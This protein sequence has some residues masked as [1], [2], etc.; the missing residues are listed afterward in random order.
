MWAIRVARRFLPA[1]KPRRHAQPLWP[2]GI[3]MAERANQCAFFLLLALAARPAQAIDYSF[4]GPT[5]PAGC[6]G[7]N[8]SY[9]CGALAFAAGDTLSVAQATAVTVNGALSVGADALINAGGSG[10]DLSFDISGAVT[11]GAGATVN[12]HVASSA[13]VTIG[14][15]VNLDGN[16]ST[17]TGAVSVGA[18]AVVSGNISTVDG[19]VTLGVGTGVSGSISTS[20]TGAISAGASSTVGGNISSATG[21]IDIGAGSVVGG[22]ISSSVNGAIGLGATVTVTGGIT[23]ATGA[24][25]VGESS[26]VNGPIASTV[27]GA[28]SL[29]ASSQAGSTVTSTSGAITIGAGGS[30]AALLSTKG[31][32]LITIGDGALINSVFCFVPNDQSCVVNNSN[33][34]MP[35]ASPP[36]SGAAAGAFECLETGSNATWSSAARKPLYTKLAGSNFSFDIAALSTNGSLV[37]NYAPAGGSARYVKVELF[38]DS[39]PPASCST[40]ANIVATQIVTFSPGA[41]SGAAGRTLSG[42][43]NLTSAHKVLRCRVTECAS[44]TCGSVTALAPS[45]SSDQFS[46]RPQALTLQTSALAPAPSAAATP[47]IKA[48]ASFNLSASA[49]ASATSTASVLTLDAGKL[50]AQVPGQASSVQSGGVVGALT[51]S[52]LTVNAS[53]VSAVYT[54]VGYLYLAPGAFRDDT[55]T[56][57]DRAAG[58]CID[59]TTGNHDLSDTLMGGKYGC[60][61]GNLAPVSF[62]R[63]IPDH[64]D[65]A[66]EAGVPMPCP[67]ALSCAPAGYVYA[68]QP[69]GV[70]VT[71]RNLA[72]ATTLNYSG[73]FSHAVT[74]QAWDAPGSTVLPN[75]PASPA[76]SVLGVSAVPAASFVAGLASVNGAASPAYRFPFAWPAAGSTL[77][78]PSAI[79]VRAIETPAGSADGVTSQR[80]SASVEGGV[81]VVAGRL[82]LGNNYGSEVLPLPINLTAQYWDGAQFVT[83]TGDHASVFNAADMVFSNCRGAL[84]AGAGVCIGGLSA[85]PASLVLVAGAARFTLNA[86]GPGNTG[87]LDV[88]IGTYPWLPSSK[89]R[90]TF[91]VYKGGPVIYSRELY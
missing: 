31:P 78:P 69:F 19:G 18:G 32:G 79:Y 68:A 34:P 65:S 59:D 39:T 7:G 67:A 55:F 17:T 51:P 44:N 86:P 25:T 4:P 75:P 35:P 82:L 12:A 47:V 50:S 64:F 2:R 57:V 20:N 23:S 63:F 74:L 8:G 1:I 22:S 6:S 16:V 5:M 21:A 83:S 90:M 62:G 43:F 13:A 72:G 84:D 70:T 85:A 52:V 30:V 56:A 60:S 42:N 80:A 73:S 38:D 48:G 26:V 58:D 41:F 10:A 77:A 33:R 36:S 49:S 27:D 15:N 14:A 37:G 81:T 45:C 89:A 53:P 66:I 61:I 29:G 91:G 11:L 3:F 9:T 54:E 40:V 71:A 46:V 76:G 28:V 24:I 87:S 88:T